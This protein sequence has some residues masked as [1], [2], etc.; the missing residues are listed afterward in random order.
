MP[1]LTF[2]VE[3]ARPIPGADP[4]IGFR[5][6]VN[7]ADATEIHSVGLRCQVRIRPARRRYTAAEQ[8]KLLDL[9][10]TPDRWGKT[11]RDLHWATVGVTVPPFVGT[12]A[13]EAPVPCDRDP[14][15]AATRYFDALDGGDAEL[16]LLFSGTVFYEA[17][18]GSA[19]RCA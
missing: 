12:T 16:L 11:V 19:R 14:T 10:G 5:L 6:R 3:G 13:V 9:F 1:D 17:D 7:T 2:T 15:A 4:A 8:T 18:G